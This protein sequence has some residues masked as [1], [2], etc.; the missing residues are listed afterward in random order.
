LQKN[1]INASRSAVN[2]SLGSVTIIQVGRY[3][4]C[5]DGSPNNHPSFGGSPD[6]ELSPIW[7]SEIK[8]SVFFTEETMTA[9]AMDQTSLD[10]DI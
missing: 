1:W 3:Q 2:L 8:T 10:E 7:G 9:L 4:Y 6:A 5:V